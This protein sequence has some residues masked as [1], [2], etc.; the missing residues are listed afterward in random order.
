MYSFFDSP[1]EELFHILWK[2]KKIFT[3]IKYDEST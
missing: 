1:G 3:F 2:I